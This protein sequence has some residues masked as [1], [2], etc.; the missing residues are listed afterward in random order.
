MSDEK[1]LTIAEAAARQRVSKQTLRRLISEGRLPAYRVSSRLIRI[2][3]EDL[4]QINRRIPT[5]T[6]P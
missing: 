6:T 2:R 1:M 3:E 4:D 5:A